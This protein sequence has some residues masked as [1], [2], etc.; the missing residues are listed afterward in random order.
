MEPRG[1]QEEILRVRPVHD[2]QN[3]IAGRLRLRRDDRE[4]P[5][6]NVIEKGRL[7]DIGQSN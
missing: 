5:P 2:P 4:L 6:Q 1:I 3:P 7:P